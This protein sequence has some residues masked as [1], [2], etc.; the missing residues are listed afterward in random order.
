MLLIAHRGN[1]SGPNPKRENTPEYIEEAISKGFN[2]EIDV[3]YE[4]Y[5][6][7]LGHDD[8]ETEITLEWLE[9]HAQK[10]WIHCKNLEA[11]RFLHPRNLFDL[12][13]FNYFWHQEDDFTLT[14]RN[15][16]WTYPQ[17]EVT[18]KS[19]IVCQTVQECE[20]YINSNAYG[21]CSDYVGTY[22]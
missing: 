8:G 5:K 22:R 10:L 11:L 17:K 12:Y 3:R 14:S 6:M 19:V 1:I 2:V 20:D 16:I 18:D 9:K 4:N 13:K 15:I 21:M 7:L